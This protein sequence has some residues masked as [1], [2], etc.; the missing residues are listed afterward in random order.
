MKLPL[1]TR[2]ESGEAQPEA[3]PESFPAV[4]PAEPA[5]ADA[6]TSVRLL[7]PLRIEAAG[8]EVATGL[9]SK[10]RELLAYL[11]VHPRGASTEA[12]ADA[13]WP[14]ADPIRSSERFH[15][16]LGNLRSTLRAAADL[17]GCAI[18]ERKAIR[19]QIDAALV[20]VICGGSRLRLPRPKAPMT[21]PPHRCAGAGGGLLRR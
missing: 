11:L 5:P 12:A 1:A 8:A 10:A 20:V 16:T 18:V 14:D 7:G 6:P 2:L 15:T 19:Y 3:E 17:D 9:R 4:E 13:L 21:I